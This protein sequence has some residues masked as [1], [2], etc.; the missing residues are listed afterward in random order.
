MMDIVNLF[1]N[2]FSIQYLSEKDK[3]LAKVI[4][5]IGQISYSP[6]A[7]GFSF[8]IH[9][10]IE[11]MLSVET[12]NKIYKRLLNL[13]KNNITAKSLLNFSIEDLKKIGTSKA[14]A[15]YILELAKAID[16]E[17]LN[18][19]QL[20][21]LDDKTFIKEITKQRGIGVWTAKMYLIF[22]LNRENILPFEDGAFLQAYKWLYKTD[23]ISPNSIK[24]RCSKWMPYSSI[25]AR[26]LYKAL[27]SGLT[28]KEF[29]LLDKEKKMISIE[30]A[31]QV[32]TQAYEDTCSDKTPDCD[33]SQFIDYVI[34]NTHKTFKY[35]LFTA[36]L[37]KA[38]DN[39]INPLC[40]QKKSSLTGAYDARSI[41]HKVIVPFEMNVLEKAL[42]GSNEPFLNKPA[43]FPELRKNNAVR[44]GKDQAILNA[45]CDN[46][47]KISSSEEATQ[48]LKYLLHKLIIIRDEKQ[49]LAQFS[50]TDSADLPVKLSF[51]IEK[52]MEKSFEGEILTLLVAGTYHL[53]L[54]DRQARIDVHPVNQCGASSREISDLDIYISGNLVSSNELKDKDY[55]EHDV[56]HA[57]D[58]VI[59][60]NGTRMLF[61]KGP[62]AQATEQFEDNLVKKYRERNFLLKIID[63]KDFF[64][65]LLGGLIQ[66]DSEEFIK[67]IFR[68]AQENKFKEET[69]QYVNSMATKYLGLY[70]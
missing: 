57:A 68:I 40:L 21:K 47:P 35:I 60:A 17:A 67:Y 3:R 29:H 26:Y 18:L 28:K 15:T 32:L 69:I 2:S 11:Q 30:S 27:D 63:W 42:G 24:K 6:H 14:K 61:I 66:V 54:K 37:S 45:L 46:L 52:T 10:I 65:T 39:N 34:D 41:C 59:K 7:D 19:E 50:L 31:K 16:S 23:D 64:D 44:R 49:K 70:R 20:N 56:I 9:E 43:R 36:I 62:R 55:Q 4:S 1:P 12:G 13:C 58:K 5:I 33:L 8:L 22:V 25:A 38:T 48:C 51:F 53:A